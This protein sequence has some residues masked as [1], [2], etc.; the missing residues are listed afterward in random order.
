[1]ASEFRVFL[2]I[3]DA[4]F[5]S[6]E[7]KLKNY[8]AT[9]KLVQDNIFSILPGA[10][11][12]VSWEDRT[13]EYINAKSSIVGV[14]IR[15]GKK[16]VEIK[17][18][19]SNNKQQ[20]HGLNDE[21]CNY[22]VEKWRKYKVPVKNKPSCMGDLSGYQR[23]FREIFEQVGCHETTW[24]RLLASPGTLMPVRKRRKN[25]AHEKVHLEICLLDSI[26]DS[27]FPW[28]SIAVESLEAADV[29]EFIT[30]CGNLSRPSIW[31][32]ILVLLDYIRVEGSQWVPM[33]IISGYPMLLQYIDGLSPISDRPTKRPVYEEAMNRLLFYES[34][35]RTKVEPA[36]ARSP[37]QRCWR[38]Q[39]PYTFQVLSWN[40]QAANSRGSAL[41]SKSFAACEVILNEIHNGIGSDTPPQLISLQEMQVCKN[42]IHHMCFR[43]CQPNKIS[44]SDD[45]CLYDHASRMHSALHSYGYE[46]SFHKKMQ[47]SVGLFWKADIFRRCDTFYANFESASSVNRG[48]VL[49]L[50]EHKQSHQKVLAIAVHLS[51]VDGH[52]NRVMKDEL[53]QLFLKVD[54][55]FKQY[56][57]FSLIIAGD[58]NSMVAQSVRSTSATSYDWLTK[59]IGLRSAYQTVCGREPMFTSVNPHC[60]DYIFYSPGALLRPVAVFDCIASEGLDSVEAATKRL[61][62]N[63]WPSD[64]IP[65][66]AEFELIPA[67]AD[68]SLSKPE[69]LEDDKMDTDENIDEQSF[70]FFAVGDFGEPNQMVKRVAQSM[71]QKAA[72]NSL[73]FILAL[74]DNIYD[75]GCMS[76]DDPQFNTKWVDIFITPY[77]TLHVPWKISLGNHDYYGSPASQ[78]EYTHHPSNPKKLWQCP[79]NIFQFRVNGSGEEVSGDE[80][81]LVEFFC[82][83]TNGYGT[84]NHVP[85]VYFIAI[86]VCCKIDRSGMS[87]MIE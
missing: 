44:G 6:S 16:K 2:P 76:V 12:S 65:I 8:L 31:D 17:V 64:H 9:D 34:L 82:M 45:F 1:M 3:L 5:T 80:K 62:C 75:D 7:K 51:A 56:G 33:P 37:Y 42:Q 72:G 66:V 68:P 53:K 49:A 47:R 36:P 58:L 59:T 55:I 10:W 4:D 15:G 14:K 21:R 28:L 22:L 77:P 84:Y 18:N 87:V 25:I 85:L 63:P 41:S 32:S 43:N 40:I 48:A 52:N 35:L 50:L 54:E 57:T 11:Q 26:G 70:S 24:D 73:K 27:G 29:T 78:I 60:V 83:D 71:A 23:E 79:S 81:A 39:T 69:E 38:R 19:A 61:S 13:D 86:C 67:A 20:H 74:G 30:Q 46:G